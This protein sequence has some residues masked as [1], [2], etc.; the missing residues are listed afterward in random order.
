MIYIIWSNFKFTTKWCIGHGGILCLLLSSTAKQE[1]GAPC[2]CNYIPTAMVVFYA[3]THYNF[4]FTQLALR[5]AVYASWDTC[6]VQCK[7]FGANPRCSP[8][9][10]I[11]S[12]STEQLISRAMCIRTWQISPRI[13]VSDLSILIK[14]D[15]LLCNR[16]L[17]NATS[18][19]SFWLYPGCSFRSKKTNPD[20]FNFEFAAPNNL[21][22]KFQ[23]PQLLWI[24]CA[25]HI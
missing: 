23:F 9:V 10:I 12:T 22:C 18:F 15:V 5:L 4:I 13:C 2:P 16:G 25:G 24:D 11:I 14:S 6:S 7:A 20:R 1:A 17:P 8:L 21:L 19:F 3:L